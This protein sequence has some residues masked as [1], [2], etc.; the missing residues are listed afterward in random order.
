MLTVSD[1]L[2]LIGLTLW[3]T[4]TIA[5]ASSSFPFDDERIKD[6]FAYVVYA[7]LALTLGTLGYKVFWG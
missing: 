2:L 6:F 1:S 7:G 3:I 4:G 5:V